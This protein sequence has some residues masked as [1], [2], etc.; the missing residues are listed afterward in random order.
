VN[1][2]ERGHYNRERI[3]A[4]FE[5]RCS[6][7]KPAPTLEDL[8][9]PTGLSKTSVYEIVQALVRRGKLVRVSRSRSRSYELPPTAQRVVAAKAFERWWPGDVLTTEV[10]VKGIAYSA[11]MASRGL[12]G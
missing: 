4:L 1:P 9:Q 5:L 12:N 6:E 3:L 2:F 11:W 7:G 8:M 10:G